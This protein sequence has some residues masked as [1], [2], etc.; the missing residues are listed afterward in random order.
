[1]LLPALGWWWVGAGGCVCGGSLVVRA[2]R[3]GARGGRVRP[4]GFFCSQPASASPSRGD[5]LDCGAALTAWGRE[6]TKDKDTQRLVEPTRVATPSASKL[7]WGVG[8]RRLSLLR[9]LYLCWAHVSH[10]CWIHAR[11]VHSSCV[12]SSCLLTQYTLSLSTTSVAS[13][14]VPPTT[15]T[16]KSRTSLSNNNADVTC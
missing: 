10:G 3:V 6:S 13:R 1:M 12:S 2:R 16:P 8:H 5:G 4:T 11:L 14:F 7:R 15:P 9:L